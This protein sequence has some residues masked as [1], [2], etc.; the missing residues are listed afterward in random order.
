LAI[1]RADMRFSRSGKPI[2]AVEA[3]ARPVTQAFESTVRQQLNAYSTQIGAPWALLADPQDTWVFRSR[4]MQPI[5]RLST[6]EM[7]EEAALSISPN[8]VGEQ[9]ILTALDRVVPQLMNRPDFLRRHPELV[10]FAHAVAGAESTF[11][12]DVRD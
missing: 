12:P 10:E 7:L 5:A 2:V 1:Y 11:D 6:A 3:K 9:V 4:D 8:V